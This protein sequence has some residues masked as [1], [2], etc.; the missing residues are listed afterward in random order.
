MTSRTRTERDFLE[1]V[2][3]KI[4]SKESMASKVTETV[5]MRTSKCGALNIRQTVFG[6]SS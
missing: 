5:K 1:M 4:P 6:L 2:E 3:A